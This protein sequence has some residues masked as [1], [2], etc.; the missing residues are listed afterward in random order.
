LVGP[1]C[2]FGGVEGARS[3][4]KLT[5]LF[6]R[7]GAPVEAVGEVVETAR[8]VG[9]AKSS[10]QGVRELTLSNL[11]L[12]VME[13]REAGVIGAVFKDEF[14]EFRMAEARRR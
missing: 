4:K 7:A 12:D 14:H 1:F 3:D 8:R 10:L 2:G 6:L 11:A 13:L 9:F 5:A